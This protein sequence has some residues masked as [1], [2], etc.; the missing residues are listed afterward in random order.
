MEL[1]IAL[2]FTQPSAQHRTTQ[3]SRAFLGRLMPTVRADA[4]R[5]GERL[6]EGCRIVGLELELDFVDVFCGDYSFLFSSDLNYLRCE[7]TRTQEGL[8]ESGIGYVQQ[9]KES[10]D[11]I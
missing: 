9:Y 6:R 2:V 7:P 10:R 1:C 11:H 4:S 3:H 5:G 8:I